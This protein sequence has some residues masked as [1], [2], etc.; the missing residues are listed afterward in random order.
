[1]L[2]K[3]ATTHRPA[4]D[5][6]FLLR[7]NPANVHR[8]DLPFGK[9]VLFYP[10]ASE[11][12]C[13][14]A[15]LLEVDPIQLVRGR[16]SSQGDGMLAHYV[17][18]RPYAASSFL[19]VAINRV[20]RDA[21]AGRAKE[22]E[23]LA[24]TAIALE[25]EITPLPCKGEDEIVHRL[26]APLGYEVET[27]TALLDEAYPDWGESPY[28]TVSLTGTQRLADALTH[29]Y[30]L[31]PVLDNAK[32]YWVGSDEVEKLIEKAGAWL[33]SHPERDLIANRY[34]RKRQFAQDALNLLDEKF[35]VADDDS[36]EPDA[37]AGE[38][39]L[40]KPMRLND[41][42]YEAIAAALVTAGVRRVCD[43]GCGEGKLLSRLM[44]EPSIDYMLGVEVSTPELEKAQRKLRLERMSPTQRAR[45]DVVR[46]S[47][48][49]DDKR[50]E[51]FDAITL[52]EVIE[53][54]DAER[55][56]ALERVVF[57]KARPGTVLVSTPNIEFN[58]TFENLKPGG[59]RHSDHRFEWTRAEFAA[60]AQSVCDRQ[61]Y[62]VHFEG[63]GD[64]HAEYGHPTQ[65]AVFTRGAAS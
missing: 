2:L 11:D 41:R 19:S 53:H 10:E 9:S 13:E 33:Q 7:K 46:G 61:G 56:D 62:E 22:R 65:M 18:D 40:E 57:A 12:R 8:A 45:I 25:L 16:K 34:L 23:D 24:D 50:L 60:W 29:L 15:L 43:L 21:M 28:R 32:H 42:R 58:Q 31:I 27:Q 17:N 63:I 30:V 5:L 26:F 52:V 55:L 38:M 37:A 64:A 4:T 51:G 59:L 20:L 49:Y 54:V 44:Q 6:G 39:E 14:A 36:E 35:G 47:L 3:I 1:M 48:V